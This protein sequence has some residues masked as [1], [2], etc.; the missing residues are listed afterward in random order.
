MLTVYLT[1]AATTTIIL[2][3]HSTQVNKMKVSNKNASSY[4]QQRREFVGSNTYAEIKNGCY[5]VYSYGKHFPMY[6][7]KDGEWFENEDKYSQTTS[8]HKSQLR[9]TNETTLLSTEKMKELI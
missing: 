8:K 1:K 7:H 4:T 9:P 3:Q 6:I 5:V 2:D